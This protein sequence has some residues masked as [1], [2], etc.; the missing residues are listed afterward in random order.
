MAD[1][2]CDAVPAVADLGSLAA[3]DNCDGN[4]SISYDGEVRTDG[5]CE[6]SYTLERTWT[7]VDCAGNSHTQTQTITVVDTQAPALSIDCPADVHENECFLR[8]PARCV[9]SRSSRC[10]G[11]VTSHHLDADGAGAIR[12]VTSDSTRVNL[13]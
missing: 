1:V 7:T 12:W 11:S 4:P 8:V 9:T 5:D 3:S 6:D 2:E 10:Y 13:A